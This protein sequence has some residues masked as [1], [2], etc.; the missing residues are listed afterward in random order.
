V[1]VHRHFTPNDFGSHIVHLNYVTWRSESPTRN[2][3]SALE[4]FHLHEAC[5]RDIVPGYAKSPLQGFVLR[6]YL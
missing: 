1:R 6:K 2:H 4:T 5:L 3:G